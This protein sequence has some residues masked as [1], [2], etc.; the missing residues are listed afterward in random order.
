MGKTCQTCKHAIAAKE[1]C[2]T[3]VS[4]NAHMHLTS[5][6][7]LLSANAIVGIKE[8]GLNIMLLCNTCLM[9]NERDSFIRCRAIAKVTE[10]IESL[11]VGDKLKSMEKRLTDLV[12]VKM[13]NVMKETCEKVDKTYS[14]IVKVEKS[15]PPVVKKTTKPQMTHDTNKSFRIQGVP[16][17]LEKTVNENLVP[18]NEA[19]NEILNMVGVSPNIVEMKRLGKFK[20][21]TPRTKPRT[22]LVT[23]SSEHEARL[24]LAR[25][26]EK[27]EEL[28][29]SNY[30]VLPA[31]SAEDA[32]K[33]NQ[34]LKRRR[35]LLEE[36]VPR[37]KLKIKNL[38]LFNDGTKVDIPIKGDKTS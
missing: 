16:E 34:V 8:L 19:V 22:L 33:E 37:E 27:R 13:G 21:E 17:D 25:C 23:V 31:L 14:A 12:D 30:F 26:Y 32:A 2:F 28:K 18:T 36:G 1:K 24:T 35:E 4:C 38:E 9:N 7:T 10:K 5:D 29:D 11:D 15:T 6:C 20:T 3:C